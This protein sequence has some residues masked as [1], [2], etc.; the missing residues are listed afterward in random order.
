[1]KFVVEKLT[2]FKIH[3]KWKRDFPEDTFDLNEWQKLYG[4]A[5]LASRETKIQSLQFKI[6]HRIKSLAKIICLREKLLFHQNASFVEQ[7]VIW[8]IFSSPVELYTNF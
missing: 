1:M 6:I 2:R 4:V 5:F 7:L 3:E 8:F